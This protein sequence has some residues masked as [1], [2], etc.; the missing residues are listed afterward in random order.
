MNLKYKLN[1]KNNAILK[2][3][4]PEIASSND[5]FYLTM[6]KSTTNEQ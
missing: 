3:I 6:L 2:L 5:E 4:T 1:N